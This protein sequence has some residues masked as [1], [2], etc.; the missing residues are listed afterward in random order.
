MYEIS[1]MYSAGAEDF[2]DHDQFGEHQGPP[3]YEQEWHEN[4]NYQDIGHFLQR[5]ELSF[6]C[7]RERGFLSFENP[8]NIIPELFNDLAF[9]FLPFQF[10]ELSV[11][12][13]KIPEDDDTV[14]EKEDYPA[15]IVN[16]HRNIEPDQ[17]H[18]GI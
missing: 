5:V 13:E 11:G 4:I 12:T 9:G 6:L 3:R 16:G 8:G 17:R 1:E 15:Y 18:V 7:Y 14:I 2:P 10:V